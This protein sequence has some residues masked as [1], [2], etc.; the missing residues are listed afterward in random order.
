MESTA[1]VEEV[2]EAATVWSAAELYERIQSEDG[3]FIL[4]VRAEDEFEAWKIEGRRDIPTLGIPYYE[5]LEVD[6]HDDVVDTFQDF[7]SQ[8]HTDGLPKDT[9]ILAVCAKG[10]T[11]EYVA[12]ALRRLGF[13]AFN[14]EGGTKAW[15]DHYHVETISESS[16]RAVVQ[17]S[18]PARGCL[19]YVVAS[20]GK[21]VVIDPLRH[22]DHYLDLARESGWTI[23]L[24]L[25]T[26]GHA[27]HIS[28]GPALAEKTGAAYHLHPYDG[29]HP[30]DVLPATISYEYVADGKVFVFGN[31]RIET[32]HIPGHTLGN[33]AYLLD[34]DT[35]FSGDSIF[36]ESIARPDLGGRGETWAPLHHASL[37]RLLALP[38]ETVILPGHFSQLAEAAS[39][40]RFVG[41]LG[42]LK[43][44]NEGLRM[45]QAG[46]EEFVTYILA[47]LPEFPEEYV[48][49]KRV[50]AGLKDVGEEAASE[51]EL[52]KNICALASSPR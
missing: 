6:E 13:D 41:R 32:L 17:I 11:S 12:E 34:G 22:V 2:S 33:V 23:E 30:L 43:D 24:V 38:A 44:G 31:S 36:L 19:S 1:T 47:S 50:N 46:K 39:D 28:G 7:L 27:D 40:G 26:H 49:I 42:D 37:R 15:G 16:E 25:D 4:D 35:L 52:G 45:V 9:P 20:Q 8:G 48:D 3:V 10:D 5:M 18:R 21:A 29:I 14:L 51:L